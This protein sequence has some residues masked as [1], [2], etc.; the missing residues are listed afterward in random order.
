MITRTSTRGNGTGCRASAARTSADA[1]VDAQHLLRQ[2]RAQGARGDRRTRAG[3]AA[4]RPRAD[5]ATA[6]ESPSCQSARCCARGMA[7]RSHSSGSRTSSRPSSPAA[8]ARAAAIGSIVLPRVQRQAR[9]APRPARR[10]RCRGLEEPDGRQQPAR[11]A[12]LL[13]AVAVDG[14]RTPGVDQP[15]GAGADRARPS[16]RLRRPRV[17]GVERIGRAD[18]HDDAAR[19]QEAARVRPSRGRAA[20]AARAG[21]ASGS[22]AT[23]RS[24]AGGLGGSE[25]TRRSTNASSSR[26]A[27][28]GFARRS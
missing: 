19:R 16:G 17:T 6:A 18:V 13:L 1:A 8:N 23:T 3:G 4:R 10:R 5:C 15:P 24:T 2:A 7:R 20:R 25:A 21:R 27:R 28:Y 11:A 14:D 22:G 9:L 12:R 26:I